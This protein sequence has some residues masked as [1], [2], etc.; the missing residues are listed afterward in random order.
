MLGTPI[1]PPQMN[2]LSIASLRLP[3]VN[4]L[5]IALDPAAPMPA[6]G[7]TTG[8]FTLLITGVPPAPIAFQVLYYFS[9]S[10]YTIT[11]PVP[12]CSN[13]ARYPVTLT[14]ATTGTATI[15]VDPSIQGMYL[16][17]LLTSSQVTVSTTPTMY[18]QEVTGPV[19]CGEDM[20]PN[21]GYPLPPAQQGLQ[22]AYLQVQLAPPAPP[23]PTPTQSPTASPSAPL[24]PTP[25]PLLLPVQGPA[26]GAAAAT[27]T[28]S[29][30]ALVIELSSGAGSQSQWQLT[31][32]ATA[33][34]MAA[35]CLLFA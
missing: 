7:D 27:P 5:A 23:T 32:A 9:A 3:R 26:N 12:E 22:L 24:N 16:T 35:C 1:F 2:T 18:L 20:A 30:N 14:G 28:P 4:T 10:A 8:A 11:G 15:P 6:L 19:V 25:L 13:A 29:S 34:C 33:A 21:P 17:F 31:L